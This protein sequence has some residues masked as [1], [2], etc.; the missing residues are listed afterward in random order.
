MSCRLPANSD[1]LSGR[2]SR[3]F[4]SNGQSPGSLWGWSP[5][6]HSPTLWQL[7]TTP[8]LDRVCFAAINQTVRRF[9]D[10]R[11]SYEFSGDLFEPL[12]Q[13]DILL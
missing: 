13:I 1:G 10:L 3:C 11:T 7:V 2:I 12:R 4:E 8:N 6:C 9:P 5:N